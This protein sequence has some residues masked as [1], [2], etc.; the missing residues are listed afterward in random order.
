MH[1]K[2]TKTSVMAIKKMPIKP[3]L[4]ACLSIL[5]T[6]PEGKVIS[7]NPKN[8]SAKRINTE[9]F[10][11]SSLDSL[12]VLVR[13]LFFDPATYLFLGL[14]VFDHAISR[15]ILQ[16]MKNNNKQTNNSYK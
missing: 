9:K 1:E 16:T 8:E 7:N 10:V 11:V 4:S 13:E 14:W 2:L 15:T 5:L 12:K 6:S 3:P